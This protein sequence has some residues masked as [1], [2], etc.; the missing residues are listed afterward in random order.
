[1]VNAF[2]LTKETSG[3]KNSKIRGGNSIS[4]LKWKSVHLGCNNPEYCVIGEEM[5]E[6]NGTGKFID[7]SG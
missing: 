1:M 2:E 7:N 3:G 5:M 6:S 4:G